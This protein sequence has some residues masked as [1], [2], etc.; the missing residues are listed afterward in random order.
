MGSQAVEQQAV[1]QA[2]QKVRTPDGRE[3]MVRISG[4]PRGRPVFL[5]HG[6][7]GSRVGPAPRVPILHRQG[8]RLISYDRPGYGGSTR[9]PGRLVRDAAADVRAIAEYLELKRFAVVGRSGGAPHALACAALLDDLVTRCVSLVAL[10]PIDAHGTEGFDW[11]AGMAPSNV[12]AY[13]DAQQ[14]GYEEFIQDLL[15]QRREPIAGRAGDAGHL[16][17]EL[18]KEWTPTDRRIVSDAGIRRQL[19]LSYQ[20]A[21]QDDTDA[22]GWVDDVLAFT[23]PWG[24]APDQVPEHVGVLL[25]HGEQDVFSP[26]SHTRWLERHI[27]HAEVTIEPGVSHFHNLRRLPRLLAWAAD[28]EE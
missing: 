5:L 8:I 1:Q 19:R 3:L 26:A 6:T 25:Y 17:E 9:R 21:L 28:G 27:P 16:I 23:R 13:R 10:A 2:D 22:G 15:R 14:E 12:E 24:F 4:D 7:P 11:Y 20:E 18:D